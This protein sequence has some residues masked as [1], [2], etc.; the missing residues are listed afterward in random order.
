[1]EHNR[2]IYTRPYN[3]EVEYLRS[4][5]TQWIDTGILNTYGIS[6]EVDF[7]I[8]NTG[9]IGVQYDILRRSTGIFIKFTSNTGRIEINNGHI[10]NKS[11][12]NNVYERKKIF[13][14][15]T[16]KTFL[17]N[18][19]E[20]TFVDEPT[21]FSHDYTLC[22]F[23]N[24]GLNGA[25]VKIYTA[26]FWDNGILVRDFIPVRIGSVGYMYDRVSGKLFGNKGTGNFTLGPDV[27]NPVPN[28]RRVFRFGNKRFVILMPYDSKIEYLEFSGNQYINTLFKGNTTTTK[29]KMIFMLHSATGKIAVFGSRNIT[30]GVDASA[31]NIFRI[32]NNLRMDWAI[33][34]NQNSSMAIN[35]NIQ[36]NIEIT[37]GYVKLNNN[38]KTYSTLDSIN[39]RYN[40]LIGNL[41][42]GSNSPYPTGFKGKIYSAQLYNN[43]VLIMDFIPV[44]KG[45]IGYLYDKVSGK[46]FG[47]SGTGQFILGNDIND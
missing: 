40:F 36:Y 1:M 3:A 46:L 11:I 7:Q 44:R 32:G 10:N 16:S 39:N 38:K 29:F 26:K 25:V 35:N 41:T 20:G 37:R 8:I 28:I 34:I 21:E 15:S 42:D 5:R 13:I 31:M 2:V 47:N 23:S 9:A 19:I 45:S 12:I 4:S 17:V 24:A 30:G 22:L 18:G 6:V 33:P 27:A 14:D 43:N